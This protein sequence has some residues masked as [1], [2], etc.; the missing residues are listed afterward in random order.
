[1]PQ[2]S[3]DEVAITEIRHLSVMN[4]KKRVILIDSGVVVSQHRLESFFHEMKCNG[5]T[6]F[7]EFML[8]LRCLISVMATSSGL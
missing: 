2:Q 6:N 8:R 5:M 4:S 7:L 1:M 3:P